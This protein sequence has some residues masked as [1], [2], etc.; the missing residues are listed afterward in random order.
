VSRLLARHVSTHNAQLEALEDKVLGLLPA[1]L[2]AA[3]RRRVKDGLVKVLA[4]LRQQMAEC[5]EEWHEELSE[6]QS[7]QT[8]EKD[9]H[10]PT[11]G[12][13]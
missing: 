13:G 1:K 8:R 12:E 6:R 5:V 4:D 3:D 9:P 7:R 2:A 10:A 11:G